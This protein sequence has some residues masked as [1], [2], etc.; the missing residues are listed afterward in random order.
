MINNTLFNFLLEDNLQGFK[1]FFE[2]GDYPANHVVNGN[3]ILEVLILSGS[4]QILSFLLSQGL[5]PNMKLKGNRTPID[6]CYSC[7]RPDLVKAFE[8]EGGKITARKT[9]KK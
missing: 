8:K 3:N 7:G 2:A 4:T 1:H 6:F 5:N 9:W